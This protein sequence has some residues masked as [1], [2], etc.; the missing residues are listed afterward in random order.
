MWTS[1]FSYV[2]LMFTPYQLTHDF[3]PRTPERIRK[4]EHNDQK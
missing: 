3:I 1:S 4:E 2:I